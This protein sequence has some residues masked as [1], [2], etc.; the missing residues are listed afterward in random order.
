MQQSCNNRKTIKKTTHKNLRHTTVLTTHNQIK[1]LHRSVE[2]GCLRHPGASTIGSQLQDGDCTDGWQNLTT[3]PWA[4][5]PP[6]KNRHP[7]HWYTVESRGW[8]GREQ[9]PL[10]APHIMLLLP[11]TLITKR[12]SPKHEEFHACASIL[13]PLTNWLAALLVVYL[14]KLCKFNLI[15]NICKCMCDNY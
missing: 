1:Q 15:Y 3:Q 5:T 8:G 12:Y 4:P 6:R 2:V 13:K 7:S 10:N 11:A 14:V 9:K